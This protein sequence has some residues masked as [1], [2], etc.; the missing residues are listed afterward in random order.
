MVRDAILS[1]AFAGGSH[2]EHLDCHQAPGVDAEPLNRDL[3]RR[4]FVGGL[5]YAEV[6]QMS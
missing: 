2:Q 6:L 1:V 5:E 3:D 4:I